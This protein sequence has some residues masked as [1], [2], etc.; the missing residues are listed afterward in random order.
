MKMSC[1]TQC[2]AI[3]L[4]EYPV[5]LDL[6]IGI[7]ILKTISTVLLGLCFPKTDRSEQRAASS[8]ALPT[9]WRGREKRFLQRRWVYGGKYER[10]ICSKADARLW[11]GFPTSKS[12]LALP[13]GGT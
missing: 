10:T 3:Q 2:A 1:F 7:D 5:R 8:Q 9:H 6:G 11:R 4:P 13:Y 12:R